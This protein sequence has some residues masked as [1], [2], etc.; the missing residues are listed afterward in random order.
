MLLPARQRN[1]AQVRVRVH[2]YPFRIRP[3]GCLPYAATPVTKV[4]VTR[5]F[6]LVKE[7]LGRN[8]EESGLV[9]D[10]LTPEAQE[11]A[12][13]GQMSFIEGAGVRAV[14]AFLRTEDFDG[15]RR[16]LSFGRLWHHYGHFTVDNVGI[17][18]YNTQRN[19]G[20]SHVSPTMIGGVLTKWRS[21]RLIAEKVWHPSQKL[22]RKRDGSIVLEM[23]V[24]GL[25]EIA[26]WVLSWGPMAKV[27]GPVELRNDILQVMKEI[28]CRYS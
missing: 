27:L 13:T 17:G 19:R 21:T 12:R 24:A 10:D 28:A 14:S 7:K 26:S 16:S 6:G 22:T 9:D 3:R 20:R 11:A 23:T 8:S 5:L 1:A 18:R 15:L 25:D 4:S 2:A